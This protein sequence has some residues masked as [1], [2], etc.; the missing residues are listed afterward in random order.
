VS[1][2]LRTGW[3]DRGGEEDLEAIYLGKNLAPVLRSGNARHCQPAAGST[4]MPVM[5][6]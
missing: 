4:L 2:V 3:L 5:L 6:Q 1:L